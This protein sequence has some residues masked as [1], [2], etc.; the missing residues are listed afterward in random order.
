MAEHKAERTLGAECTAE[1]EYLPTVDSDH[2]VAAVDGE[3]GHFLQ[4]LLHLWNYQL[5]GQNC[6]EETNTHQTFVMFS[7]IIL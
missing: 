5:P 4:H 1:G 6:L 3:F 7:L 2:A